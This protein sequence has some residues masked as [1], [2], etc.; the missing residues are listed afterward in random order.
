MKRKLIQNLIV[1]L[2]V[3]HKSNW[4]IE[5]I[6][7]TRKSKL[8]CALVLA[9]RKVPINPPG[10]G[11]KPLGDPLNP[12]YT[13]AI[14]DTQAIE[15]RTKVADEVDA[16]R[17]HPRNVKEQG[18]RRTSD[19][20]R[21]HSDTFTDSDDSVNVSE[22]QGELQERKSS[23]D[24]GLRYR[25][26]GAQA[27]ASIPE[28]MAANALNSMSVSEDLLRDD[29]DNDKVGVVREPAVD[30]PQSPA[31]EGR[32]MVGGSLKLKKSAS[33]Q[34]RR[35]PGLTV[36]SCGSNPAQGLEPVQSGAS[37]ASRTQEARIDLEAQGRM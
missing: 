7:A 26:K 17:L 6:R 20:A 4:F 28:T 11:G 19:T 24:A 23:L 12:S 32:L 22:H 30:E 31:E 27:L 37:H 3:R 25:G 18:K 29:E 2:Q 35:K 10:G 33:V 14:P 21:F 8:M 9:M 5:H 13:V 16:A 1:Q 15:T 34:G 36:S